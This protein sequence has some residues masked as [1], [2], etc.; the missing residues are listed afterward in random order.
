MPLK[1]APDWYY[2][3]SAHELN[4]GTSVDLVAHPANDVYKVVVKDGK[5]VLVKGK[6][7]L[8]DRLKI[9]DK[10]FVNIPFGDKEHQ[11]PCPK[12]ETCVKL[13]TP[14]AY[15][16]PP[17]PAPVATP[18]PAHRPLKPSSDFPLYSTHKHMGDVAAATVE[19]TEIPPAVATPAPAVTI[20]EKNVTVNPAPETPVAA[21]TPDS[22]QNK[23]DETTT[24]S[25]PDAKPKGRYFLGLGAGSGVWSNEYMRGNEENDLDM[26]T[27]FVQFEAG[28]ESKDTQFKLRLAKT[29]GQELVNECGYFWCSPPPS[30]LEATAVRAE[31]THRWFGKK[32]GLSSKAAVQATEVSFGDDCCGVYKDESHVMA[33]VLP[34]GLTVG[35]LD[36]SYLSLHLGATMQNITTD[37]VGAG[38]NSHNDLS[39]DTEWYPM[40]DLGFR[41]YFGDGANG[42]R[43]LMALG[44]FR[45][46]SPKPISSS[47]EEPL[48]EG[49]A[50]QLNLGVGYAPNERNEFILHGGF[51][52]DQ[53][54]Y[55]S[56]IS[57]ESLTKDRRLWVSYRHN[58]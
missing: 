6:D 26:R 58:F 50:M 3:I 35:D 52:Y 57:S 49:A 39:N 14:P 36:G 42:R 10:I 13:P 8:V 15:V 53:S 33:D 20:I 16:P 56:P 22:T 4:K 38:V 29:T 17:T 11:V 7:K 32:V 23:T 47:S 27:A 51:G 30:K 25:P 24:L 40:L 28:Y 1:N 41:K 9:G 43:G 46:M 19:P 37:E 54:K 44:D 18:V 2:A 21:T 5:C 34:L 12:E 45:Y 31:G 55:Q 48:K